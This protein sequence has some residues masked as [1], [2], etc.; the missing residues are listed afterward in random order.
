MLQSMSGD[1]RF[2][3]LRSVNL[4]L[5]D[6]GA[7]GGAYLADFGPGCSSQGYC[8]ALPN[9][10]GVPASIGMQGEASRSLNNFTLSAIDLPPNAIAIFASGTAPIDPGV[11]FGNGLRCIGGTL[12]RH[13]TLH[14]VTGVVIDFQDLT[15]PAYF[16]VSPGQVLY[17]QCVY[18]DPAAGGALFNTTDAL[19][20]TFCF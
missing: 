6:A 8:T 16:G 18:R 20:V 1:G 9:S 10:T 7:T 3:A 11:P 17:Y 15:S 14:A 19:A 13:H 2:L 5:P 12:K 4:T